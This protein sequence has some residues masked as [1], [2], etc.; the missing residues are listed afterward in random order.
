MWCVVQATF[1][2]D[3]C[4]S[5][6]LSNKG[7][8][9]AVARTL[10]LVEE[11]KTFRLPKFLP[12]FIC[13][14]KHG[15]ATFDLEKRDSLQAASNKLMYKTTDSQDLKTK[16]ENG[17]VK[18]LCH[19]KYYTIAINNLLHISISP[20]PVVEASLTLFFLC[21]YQYLSGSKWRLV[22]CFVCHSIFL[23]FTCFVVEN[24]LSHTFVLTKRAFLVQN[25]SVWEADL[26]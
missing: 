25:L 11:P 13:L 23:D 1:S 4:C 20:M 2:V 18:W 24:I 8:D 17:W 15:P 26:C 12:I 9:S 5:C 3:L 6:C 10:H 22:Q 21:H 7:L 16:S 19:W 14:I